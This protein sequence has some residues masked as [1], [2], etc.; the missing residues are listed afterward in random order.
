[1]SKTKTEILSLLME[2]NYLSGAKLAE[3]LGVSRTA[4]WKNMQ[5]LKEDGYNIEAVTNKGYRLV[6]PSGRINES[7]LAG[8]VQN[9]QLSMI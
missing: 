4:V 9:S 6:G 8:T 5:R 2:G 7:L 1:M 3:M